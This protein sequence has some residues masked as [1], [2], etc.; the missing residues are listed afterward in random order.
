MLPPCAESNEAKL[1]VLKPYAPCRVRGRPE[2]IDKSTQVGRTYILVTSFLSGKVR[3]YASQEIRCRKAN[4]AR[5]AEVL[6]DSLLRE[7][8]RRYRSEQCRV[9]Q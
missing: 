6:V 7:G 9:R 8:R 2:I 3:T 1:H 5:V 4:S